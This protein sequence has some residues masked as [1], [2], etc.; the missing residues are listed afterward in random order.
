MIYFTL[1][2]NTKLPGTELILAYV[3]EKCSETKCTAFFIY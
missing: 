1:V 3:I 2:K